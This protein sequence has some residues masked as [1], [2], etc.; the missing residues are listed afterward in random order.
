MSIVTPLTLYILPA[1]SPKR[2][3]LCDVASYHE[4]ASDVWLE[5]VIK[6]A[7][8]E[9]AAV[10]GEDG[11]HVAQALLVV[12]AAPDRHRGLRL[13]APGLVRLSARGV[14]QAARR[15]SS[16]VVGWVAWVSDR[17]GVVLRLTHTHG[18]TFHWKLTTVK[19]TL[20]NYQYAPISAFHLNRE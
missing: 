15:Q 3:R 12:A 5:N 9:V 6:G 20:L 13:V 2:P 1:R 4:A 19:S 17:L 7:V 8:G 18:E 16:A 10:V 11:R 14:E